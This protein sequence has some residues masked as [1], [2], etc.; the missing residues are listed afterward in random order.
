MK[1]ALL[2]YPEFSPFG[3][4]N[5]RD[6]CRLVDAKYPAA[7][8]GMITLA[9]LLPRNWDIRLIDMNAAELHDSDIDWS[10]LV[11]IG[12]MLSQQV[13]FLRLIDRVH[14]RGKKVV[15]GGPDP[16]S[17]P[18][19]YR[20]ADY[21]VLGEAEDTIIPF[22]SDLE[23]GVKRGSYLPH[24]NKPDITLSP[25]P[26]FDLLDIDNYMMIGV[27]F[28]RG[29]P[30]D[31]EFCD[32]IELYGRKPRTKTPNQIVKELDTLYK[33]GY[34]GH[35]DFVDDNFIGHRAKAEEILRAV[36][37]W[38]EIHNYPFFFSTEASINLADH[39]DLLKL[40]ED[41]DLRYLF[42]GIE[43]PDEKVLRS[44]QKRQNLNRELYDDLHK[45]YGY[46]MIVNGGFIIGFDD[47]TS[48][49]ARSIADCVDYGKIGMP[50][51]GLLYALPNTQLTRRLTRE[52]RLFKNSSL[53]DENDKNSIDQTTCGLNFVTKRPRSEIISDLIYVLEKVY[54]RKSYFGRCLKLGMALRTSRKHKPSFRRKL[55]TVRS[56]LRLIAKLG[57]RPSTCYYFW[58]NILVILLVR[59]SSA[60]EVAN[61]MA[62]YIHFRKQTRHT[63][64]LMTC[65][66]RNNTISEVEIQNLGV[67]SIAG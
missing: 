16:T 59:P 36:R 62:M 2:I 34:R 18:K 6:V 53:L 32:I 8:L 22:L 14:A 40:M 57:L 44:S 24:K 63:I 33:L 42:I 48:E 35:V 54:E 43:S 25:V 65:A 58:R 66:L 64:E 30:Y 12:G 41:I 13:N 55:K 46:G 52:N 4:W 45:I 47:E 29:C 37:D 7:P 10:D 31:C 20:K 56:L 19:I 67:D 26:R 21:L 5:Y 11:F 39:E 49:T 61:L 1:N 60:E 28:S 17:Q 3:F 38:S 51:I 15:A 23:R 50:M 9:A 27:Q